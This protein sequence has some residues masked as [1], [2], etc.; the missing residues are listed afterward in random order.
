[1]NSEN[2]AFCTLDLRKG[3]KI[4]WALHI[5]FGSVSVYHVYTQFKKEN[6]KKKKKFRLPIKQVL[7]SW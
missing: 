4:Q 2:V 3:N 5:Q 1:M 6:D 7:L